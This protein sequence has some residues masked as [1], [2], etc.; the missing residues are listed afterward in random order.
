[1]SEFTIMRMNDCNRIVLDAIHGPKKM[2]VFWICAILA[3]FFNLGLTNVTES[4][5]A[6]FVAV[7]T[8]H[9]ESWTPLSSQ[10]SAFL[11]RL[12]QPREVVPVCSAYIVR[13]PAAL[14]ALWIIGCTGGILKLLNGE[15]AAYLGKWLLLVS[16][17]VWSLNRI[18]GIEVM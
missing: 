13:L 11:V 17:P 2:F 9:W 12:S 14:S 6:F 8:L 4:E 3:V 16:Y 15:K 10:I 5:G 18:A 7:Q 1:M